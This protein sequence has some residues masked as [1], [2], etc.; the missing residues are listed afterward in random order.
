MPRREYTELRILVDRHVGRKLGVAVM[1]QLLPPWQVADLRELVLMAQ[2]FG[3]DHFNVQVERVPERV[4]RENRPPLPEPQ[5]KHVIPIQRSTLA[6]YQ[7]IR[8]RPDA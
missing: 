5:R 8:S 4:G 7:T 2:S 3:V 6:L 1:G